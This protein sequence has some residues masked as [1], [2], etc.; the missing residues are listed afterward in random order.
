MKINISALLNSNYVKI[1]LA[2]A[3]ILYIICPDYF[4]Q[5]SEYDTFQY[6]QYKSLCFRCLIGFP[7]LI[8]LKIKCE[9]KIILLAISLSISL[10]GSIESVLSLMQLLGIT[11]SKHSVFRITGSLYNPGPLGGYLAVCEAVAIAYFI[12]NKLYLPTANKFEKYYF[13]T[14][15]LLISVVLPATF[16]RTAWIAL[17]ISVG[18]LILSHQDIRKY[19][20]N[21]LRN[22]VIVSVIVCGLI[23][24]VFAKKSVSAS[25]RFMIWKISAIAISESPIYGNEN[26][27]VAYRDAS[28]KYFSQ[29]T[30]SDA[31]FRAVDFVDNAFNE[32]LEVAVRF[33]IPVSLIFILIIAG[34]F[35]IGHKHQRFEFCAGLLAWS[36]FAC[37]SYPLHIANF[38]ILLFFCLLGCV[39][40]NNNKY[41]LPILGIICFIMSIFG[42]KYYSSKSDDIQLL[43]IADSYY[44]QRDYITAAYYYNKFY[45][46]LSYNKTYMYKYGYSLFMSNQTDKAITIFTETYNKNGNPNIC[47]ILG[48]LYLRKGDLINAEK[49][50]TQTI[51]IIPNRIES[52]NLLIDIYSREDYRNELL[53]TQLKNFTKTHKFKDI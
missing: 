1:F 41:F 3:V 2:F 27:E 19:L 39:Y 28:I 44:S 4:L 50:L 12:K 20:K 13:T 40:P 6:C 11:E 38:V 37:A 30:Y 34:G 17:I 10:C 18:Y 42:Y 46:Q 15:I 53:E 47:K 16:S 36:I 29:K 23:A 43:K 21:N 35:W 8:I 31:E 26:F 24:G 7:L 52:Y 32:Y 14:S 45:P 5:A 25:G 49:Y 51:N 33:G 22:V 48:K 9:T